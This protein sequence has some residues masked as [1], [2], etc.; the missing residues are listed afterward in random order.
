MIISWDNFDYNEN[1]RHQ[2]L[3]EP[4]KHVS[5]TTG[6]L[7]IGHC[8][9]AGGLR[10]SMFRPEVA[11]RPRDIYLSTGNQEDEILHS[12]QRYWIAEAIRYTH[13]EADAWQGLNASGM[14]GGVSHAR[15]TPQEYPGAPPTSIICRRHTTS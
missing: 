1:V 10:R 12:C 4:G 2:T 9:P 3:R 11:L 13:R 6:K 5:A 15:A 8:M 14:D 7:C